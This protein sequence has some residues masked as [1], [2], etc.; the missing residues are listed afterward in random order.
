MHPPEASPVEKLLLKEIEGQPEQ[1][2]KQSCFKMQVVSENILCVGESS[3]SYTSSSP[4][5]IT[6]MS[7]E[8]TLWRCL[9]CH[10]GLTQCSSSSGGGAGSIL[11]LLTALAIAGPALW[12]SSRKVEI[13]E[14][15]LTAKN[16]IHVT[17]CDCLKWVH[18]KVSCL[19]CHRE[20]H[21]FLHWASKGN[22]NRGTCW[23]FPPWTISGWQ[24][25][26]FLSGWCD[27]CCCWRR[28]PCF[29][30]SELIC[31]G[32]E[33]KWALLIMCCGGEMTSLDLE[34]AGC[35]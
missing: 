24:S 26:I 11:L 25:L 20:Q 32:N 22:E 8:H 31:E 16:Y 2:R 15:S 9:G 6:V 21:W 10:W 1:R 34:N 28:P 30:K 35:N 27:Y 23:I 33:I 5:S 14:G 7:P 4:A 3:I 17:G 19:G 12:V 13:E 18:L 29:L